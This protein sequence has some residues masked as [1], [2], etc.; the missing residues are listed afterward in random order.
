MAEHTFSSSSLPISVLIVDDDQDI[1]E[2]IRAVVEEA[3]YP[4]LEARDG[5]EALDILRVQPAPLIVLTNHHMPCLDGPGLLRRVL[6]APT[7]LTGHAYLYMTAGTPDLPLDLRQVLTALQAPVLFKPFSLDVLLA[8]IADA[9]HR[10]RTV[11]RRDVAELDGAGARADN[12]AGSH[13]RHATRVRSCTVSV[14]QL[15]T[16]ISGREARLVGPAP[17]ERRH[18]LMPNHTVLLS[19]RLPD[20]PMTPELTVPQV[21]LVDDT[22]ELRRLKRLMLE[23][24]NYVVAEVQDGQVA[25][26]HLRESTGPLVVVMNTRIPRVDAA[27]ILRAVVA[28]PMLQRHA[29]VLTTAL[30]RELPD[31]LVQLTCGLQVQVLGKPFTQQDLLSAVASAM[32]Q[33]P[34]R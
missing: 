14:L 32:E 25:L 16:A 19:R 7:L 6:G 18:A 29:F 34:A 3:G 30:A 22:P 15:R 27:G 11:Q 8:A 24:A 20:C 23:Q 31:A 10:L 17:D 4:V 26:T 2:T 12:Q 13:Q 21:L 1:R 9:A 28:E 33:L 5:V